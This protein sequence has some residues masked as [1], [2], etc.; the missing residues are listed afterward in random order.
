MDVVSQLIEENVRRAQEINY[1]LDKNQSQLN[2]F[3]INTEVLTQ[4]NNYSESIINSFYTIFGRVKGWF[5]KKP[6]D[7]TPNITYNTNPTFNH[8]TELNELKELSRKMNHIL[9]NQNNELQILNHDLTI[10]DSFIKKNYKK[11][12]KLV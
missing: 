1:I 12:N 4:K 2:D 10:Q 8:K 6:I 7:Y 3:K 11:I 9:E 5:Y